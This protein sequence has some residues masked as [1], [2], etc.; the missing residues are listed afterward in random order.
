MFWNISNCQNFIV[1]LKWDPFN[2]FIIPISQNTQEE[3]IKFYKDLNAKVGK[4]QDNE[5][6]SNCELVLCYKCR[7]KWAH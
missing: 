2:I 4:E 3:I 7:E 6:V 1:K 5:I